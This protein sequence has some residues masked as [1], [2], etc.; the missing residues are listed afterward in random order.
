M[1][2][3]K[4]K[5][6]AH[7]K[8]IYEE[9][10]QVEWT[11]ALCERIN[12]FC[13]TSSH[14]PT[15]NA[16]TEKD[17][18]LIAYADSVHEGEGK[19]SLPVMQKFWS[20]YL[21][22][23]VNTIHFLPFYPWSSDDGFSVIDYGRIDSRYG[24]WKDVKAFPCQI[25]AD[26]VFNHCSSQ[27]K[28]FQKALKGDRD[29]LKNFVNFSQEEYDNPSF[30]EKLKMVTRPR[31]HPLLTPYKMGEETRW[32]WTTFSEDQIDTNYGHFVFLEKTVAWLLDYFA[33]GVD[34]V[35]ID[36]VPFFWK[37]VG[38]TS[39]HH[40]KTH[41]IVKLYR[42]LFDSVSENKVL[43][44]ESNVPHKENIS[45]WGDGNN[46]AHLV[47]NFTLPSLLVHAYEF[48]TAEKLHRWSSSLSF[49]S[50]TCGFFNINATHDGIGV[51]GLEGHVETVDLGRICE[52]VQSKGGMI[53]YKTKEDGSEVPYELNI[54]WTSL[55]CDKQKD[56]EENLRK[57]LSSH[58]HV[59]SFPGVPALYIHNFFAS[60]NA[61]ELAHESGI[62]RRI[63]REKL[64]YSDAV[65]RITQEGFAKTHF[66]SLQNM[67]SIRHE[68]RAFHP[69][70]PQEDVSTH[71]QVWS[72]FRGEGRDRIM[73]LTSFASQS[74][75]VDLSS[76]GVDGK[77]KNLIDK[78]G[79]E[80]SGEIVLKSFETLW[81]K[82]VI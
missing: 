48:E 68:E 70:A 40:P 4:E 26:A 55:I 50:K 72:Y 17:T 52:T 73:V 54:T 78:T 36:A 63:N 1:A 21:R 10:Y 24:E 27:N 31:T 19:A 32:V 38:T 58:S 81:L 7:L 49:D 56:E 23:S 80:C 14:P 57:L 3:L 67:L 5:I 30:Q 47:Y 64:S 59:L 35:R 39:S 18:V 22:E 29:A 82:E 16:L 60:E 45:Y 33:N 66:E 69:F 61:P 42:T 51:R 25:M 75:S 12:E 2:S 74:L 62:N 41:E 77:M 20:E 43:I 8:L 15:S 46:E 53:N 6:E 11:E 65:A 34:W 44:T 76:I 13:E 28:V 9:N 37:E 71:P 79:D